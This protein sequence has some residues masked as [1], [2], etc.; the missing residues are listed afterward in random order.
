MIG[1]LT[2]LTGSKFQNF[3]RS[4]NRLFLKGAPLGNTLR[5][6]YS[7]YSQMFFAFGMIKRCPTHQIHESHLQIPSRNFRRMHIYARRF[8]DI[9]AKNRSNLGPK[10]VFTNLVQIILKMY[11]PFW[12]Q[13]R[14][15]TDISEISENPQ[16]QVEIQKC[17]S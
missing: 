6:T 13:N 11:F 15:L 5:K 8:T 4:F 7:I 14:N 9:S 16:T 1:E 10:C 3:L 17:D 2:I 12:H